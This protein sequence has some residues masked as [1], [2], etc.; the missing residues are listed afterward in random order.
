MIVCCE[1]TVRTTVSD[2]DL[3]FTVSA[4]GTQ[5]SYSRLTDCL[6]NTAP[7]SP[8]GTP[9]WNLNCGDRLRCTGQSQHHRRLEPVSVRSL[10]E[11]PRLVDGERP[12]VFG[13]DARRGGSDLGW[14]VA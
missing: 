3:L 12:A 7:G 9:G 13:P 11:L 1:H 10:Q 14:L 4:G 8:L 5:V 6:D 2:V